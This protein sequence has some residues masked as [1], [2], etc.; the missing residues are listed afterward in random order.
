MAAA[1]LA[2]VLLVSAGLYAAV[3][4]G[5]LGPLE[6]IAWPW[7]PRPAGIDP[8][9]PVDP[10]RSYHLTVWDYRLPFTSPGG[11]LFSASAEEAIR[12]FEER[13][14]NVEVDLVLID[15]ADGPAK[16]AEA[17]ATGYPP[18]VY[19]SPYGNAATGSDLQVPIGL[20]L[21]YEAWSEYHPV[22][23]QA[24]KSGGTVW[25]WPRWLLLWPWL[26][27]RDLLAQ[28]GIDA[29]RVSRDG[30]TREEFAAAVGSLAPSGSSGTGSAPV[31]ATS[32]AGVLRDLLLGGYLAA[33]DPEAADAY[34]LGAETGAVALWLGD[35]KEA[36]ALLQDGR[37]TNPGVLDSFLHGR[38]AILA[39]P[40]PWVVDFLLE[41][42]PR[43]E[44]WQFSL[45]ETGGRPSLV[46]LPPPHAAGAPSVV[47]VT[48]AAVSVFRQQRYRGDDNTRLAA[49]L[50]RELTT[51]LRPWLRDEPLCLPSSLSELASWEQGQGGLGQAAAFA[52]RALEQLEALPPDRLGR[53]LDVLGYGPWEAS[54][55]DGAGSNPGYAA[56]GYLGPFLESVVAPA[57]ER[58]WQEDG[59]PADL[60]NDITEAVVRGQG[61][62]QAP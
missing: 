28:A 25:S 59:T 62:G 6:S 3:A 49:E 55:G 56:K 40:S 7:R 22:A 37:G 57:M 35:L 53:A 8:R 18:D 15:L 38:S 11:A 20:Y 19:C 43:P 36:G 44:P 13:H 45:P 24:V 1:A 10:G 60:I 23:W 46:L 16:M 31:A 58:F 54:A 48:A 34:W 51:G 47:W 50:A 42:V 14:P 17:L 39:G 30:W 32:P 41:P 9:A 61:S 27:N 12:R 21:D 5:A 26:G 52:A 29:D 4:L 2:V 33:A